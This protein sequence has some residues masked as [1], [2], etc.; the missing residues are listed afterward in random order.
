MNLF[1]T[2]ISGLTP[3]KKQNIEIQFTPSLVIVNYQ[4]VSFFHSLFIKK[5]LFYLFYKKFQSIFEK[6]KTCIIPYVKY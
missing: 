2:N 3:L 4:L 6:T 5:N 1:S